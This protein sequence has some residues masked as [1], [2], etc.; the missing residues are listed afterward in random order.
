[1]FQHGCFHTVK[2]DS[3]QDPLDIEQITALAKQFV[4]RSLFDEAA[5]FFAIAQRLDPENLGIRLS[6]AQVRTQQRQRRDQKQ[7]D[8]GQ[9]AIEQMRRSAI[10]AFQFFGLAALYD[11]RGQRNQAVQCLDI[12]HSKGVVNPFVHKLRGKILLYRGQY[13]AAAE[14][15]SRARR[16]N[17]FDRELCELQGRAEYEREQYQVALDATIDAFWLLSKDDRDGTDRIKKRIRDLKMLIGL[18][19]EELVTLFHTR[20]DHLQTAFDRLEWQREQ[21]LQDADA[22]NGLLPPTPPST[23]PTQA[24]RIELAARLRPFEAFAD[25]DDVEIFQMCEAIHPEQADRDAHLFDY[26]SEGTDIYLVERGTVNI[27]RST[28]YGT[29]SLGRVEAGSLLGEINFISRFQRSADASASEPCTLLRVDTGELE[30]LIRQQ[31][32][33]G[34]KIYQAFWRSLSQKLRRANEQLST[35]F[36]SDVERECLHDPTTSDTVLVEDEDKIKVLREQG[37][38]GDELTT[39]ATFSEVKRFAAENFLF[40]EGDDGEEMYVVLEGRVLISKFIPGGGEEAL[41]ILERGDFF[42]EMSLI[43]GEPRS[44]DAKAHQGSATVISFDERTFSE[45]L[46]MD[47][48]VALQFMALLCRLIGKRL[49]EIDEKLTSWRIMAGARDIEDLFP[50]ER[51]VTANGQ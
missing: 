16:Y 7:R 35:F 11:E 36:S 1:M 43:D 6:L 32:E 23:G 46:A 14:T 30:Q 33:L 37:L 29:I 44:A 25:L 50:A 27:Q 38:S 15:L 28:D 12:A 31:P 2:T 8:M 45:V 5:E 21:L 18:P 17:P 19:H 34:L 51:S 24:G 3:T 41:A 39:L 48:R 13:D 9:A 42:G 22:A 26:R 4:E 49:R 40:H 20:R 47:P 10:D